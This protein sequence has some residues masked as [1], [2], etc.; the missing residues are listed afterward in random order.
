MGPWAPSGKFATGRAA[1][2]V[3]P[4]WPAK[5]AVTGP[6]AGLHLSDGN[7]EPLLAAGCWLRYQHPWGR[8]SL[9]VPPQHP[10]SGQGAPCP[11]T[12][13]ASVPGTCLS[14]QAWVVLSLAEHLGPGKSQPTV[15]PARARQ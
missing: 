15:L 10:Q 1:Q 8:W 6:E 14:R 2:Q 11:V 9:G 7:R 13:G 12:M 5:G 3:G 4:G